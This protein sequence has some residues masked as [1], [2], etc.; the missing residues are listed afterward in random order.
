MLFRSRSGSIS[1]E[2]GK[3]YVSIQDVLNSLNIKRLEIQKGRINII[4]K[5]AHGDTLALSDIFFRVD[6]LHVDTARLGA[7]PFLF[8]D[9]IILQTNNQ[10]IT[11]DRGD[12]RLRFKRLY[13]NTRENLIEIDS[14]YISGSK[15]DVNTGSFTVFIDSVK[16][17]NPNFQALYLADNLEVDSI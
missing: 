3:V 2:I 1:E 11:W 13:I 14:C 6:N 17:V 4:D 8:S 15:K 7:Q 16:L 9:D 12:R 10:D 5:Y